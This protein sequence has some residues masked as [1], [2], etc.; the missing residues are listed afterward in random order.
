MSNITATYYAARFAAE[1]G[2]GPSADMP[3]LGYAAL[4]D[5]TTGAIGLAFAH[6]RNTWVVVDSQGQVFA[7]ATD[8]GA[9]AGWL[10][11]YAATLGRMHRAGELGC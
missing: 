11:D 10:N 6:E 5:E 8:P 7:E 2:P 3:V 1:G 4:A 9:L